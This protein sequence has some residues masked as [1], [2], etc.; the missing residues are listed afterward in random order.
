MAGLNCETN[1]TAKYHNEA[2]SFIDYLQSVANNYAVHIN[3]RTLKLGKIY[4]AI[5]AV[6]NAKIDAFFQEIIL[7]KGLYYYSHTV[8]PR[9]DIIREVIKPIF[10]LLIDSIFVR[11]HSKSLKRHISGKITD[12]FIPGD[13]FDSSAHDYEML[14]RKWDSCIIS[15]YDFI[16]DLDDLLTKFLLEKL[17]HPKGQKSPKFNILV[18]K[19]SKANI[20]YEKETAQIFNNVHSLRTKGLHRLERTLKKED[21]S[22]LAIRIYGYFQYYDEFQESQ[23]EKTIKHEGK[24][25]RRIKYGYE[26]RLDENGKP[27]LDEKGRPYN[28]YE[29]AQEKPC[30]DCGAVLGQYH[31]SGCDVEQCPVC[32]GQALGCGCGCELDEYD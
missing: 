9:H 16:K 1:I 20:I 25:Y 6:S 26:K 13:F 29:M 15:N 23:K 31:C 28:W 7:N 30:H 2:K 27:Y 32:K 18:L 8:H 12:P 5:K 4:L 11:T 21:V 19:A 17:N 3:Y 22:E 14:F 24:W 10:E